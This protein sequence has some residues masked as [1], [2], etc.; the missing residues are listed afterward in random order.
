MKTIE[1]IWFTT[2]DGTLGITVIEEDVTGDR[3]A[4]IGV[5]KGNNEKV[6]EKRIVAFGQKL[7]L[8]IIERLDYHLRQK[9]R[10][11]DSEHL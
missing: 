6:D 2:F 1:I 8:S 5:V 10:R 7:P 9:H 4:Y 3:K 11:E